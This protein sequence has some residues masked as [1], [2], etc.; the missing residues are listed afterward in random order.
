MIDALCR[1]HDGC[2]LVELPA[3][4]AGVERLV[5]A[6]SEDR[7]KVLGPDAAEQHLYV[8]HRERTAVPVARGTGARSRGFR[9]DAK[10][11]AFEREHRA[12]A[13]RDRVN[14]HHRRLEPDT[15]DAGLEAL[16]HRAVVERDIG[17]RSAHVEGDQAAATE[18]LRDARGRDQSAGRAGQHG[19]AGA[20]GF[21]RDEPAIALHEFEARR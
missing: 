18:A 14:V 21:G 7:R 8:R 3:H 10:A 16:R 1:G 2:Q 4:D 17:R 12:A 19:I 15:R 13:R 20:K 5:A 6:C 11:A 9:P